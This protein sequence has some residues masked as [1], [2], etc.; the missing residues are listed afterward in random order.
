LIEIDV[1]K[2]SLLSRSKSLGFLS[3]R[4]AR[5]TTTINEEEEEEKPPVK[6]LEATDGFQ[7]KFTVNVIREETFYNDNFESFS[8]WFIDKCLVDV[9]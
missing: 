1:N 9:C 2:K 8:F 3:F 5:N 4:Q 6:T 7:S